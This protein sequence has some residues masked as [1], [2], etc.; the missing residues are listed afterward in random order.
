MSATPMTWSDPVD[1]STW[2]VG[3]ITFDSDIVA[4][5]STGEVL[6]V[7]TASGRVYTLFRI[8]GTPKPETHG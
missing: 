7:T 6:R 8:P 4:L 1:P 5:E 2:P 3:S